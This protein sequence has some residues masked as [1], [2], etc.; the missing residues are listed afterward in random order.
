MT[1][2]QKIYYINNISCN[3]NEVSYYEVNMMHNNYLTKDEITLIQK[4]R[5]RKSK[6][7]IN[8]FKN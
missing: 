8:Q 2:D 6:N 4:K 3:P 5:K 7:I 1:D